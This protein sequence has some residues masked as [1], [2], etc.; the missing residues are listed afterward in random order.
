MAPRDAGDPRYDRLAALAREHLKLFI[1]RD[2]ER[3]QQESER[4][5]SQTGAEYYLRFLFNGLPDDPRRGRAVEYLERE[6]RLVSLG[7]WLQ[8]RGQS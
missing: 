6:F 3:A 8:V 4:G 2:F 5:N 1:E 7:D